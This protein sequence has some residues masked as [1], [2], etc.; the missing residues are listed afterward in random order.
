M[1]LLLV[2]H[3]PAVKREV[4]HSKG[5]NDDALR[6]LTQS[7][8]EKMRRYAKALRR[9][10]GDIS[11]LYSSP[12]LRAKQTAEIL[13]RVYGRESE[14]V[15]ELL[16]ETPFKEFLL[17]LQS[18]KTRAQDQVIV[19]VGHEPHLSL[20]AGWLLTGEIESV[21]DKFEK[22]GACLLNFPLKISA[23]KAKLVWFLNP[24]SR[25]KA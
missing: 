6:P 4:F 17:W 3:A 7:G 25:D 15:E 23:G 12:L 9:R 10:L 18:K 20:L 13:G 5:R 22:G 14:I 21:F 1:R 24:P 16:P 11:S 8:Q 2:R 19:I